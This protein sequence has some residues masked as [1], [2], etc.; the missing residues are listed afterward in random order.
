VDIRVPEKFHLEAVDALP[1]GYAPKNFFE[2]IVL[3][4][5]GEVYTEPRSKQKC[6]VHVVGRE[7][8]P[9]L[10]VYFGQGNDVANVEVGCDR[11][12]YEYWDVGEVRR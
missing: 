4:A 6:P 5:L 10:L 8:V 11:F 2:G 12:E 9:E 7:Y 1:L 3:F